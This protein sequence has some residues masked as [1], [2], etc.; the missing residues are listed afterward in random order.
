MLN[1]LS[2]R[3]RLNA[4]LT[5]LA[6]LLAITGTIGVIGM[7]ASDVNINEIYTNQLASTSLVGKAQ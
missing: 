5:L 1:R 6:L 2:I 3:F 4:S 7:R